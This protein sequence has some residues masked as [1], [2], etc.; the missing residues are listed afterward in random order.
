MSAPTI[1]EK[2]KKTGKKKPYNFRLAPELMEQIDRDVAKRNN[3]RTR[4][5]ELI[6]RLYLAM[7]EPER[8]RLWQSECATAVC[9]PVRQA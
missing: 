4:L 6:L 7:S 3:S 8:V 9:L 2:M 1:G 5:L